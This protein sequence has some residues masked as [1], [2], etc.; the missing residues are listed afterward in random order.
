MCEWGNNPAGRC[1]PRSLLSSFR[2]SKGSARH[3]A[4]GS[5]GRGRRG[6]RR[7]CGAPS[8]ALGGTRWTRSGGEPRLGSFARSL[9]VAVC[10]SAHS[11]FPFSLCPSHRTAS[12]VPKDEGRPRST[13]LSSYPFPSPPFGVPNIPDLPPSPLKLP[14][15]IYSCAHPRPDGPSPLYARCRFH[16]PPLYPFMNLW[17]KVHLHSLRFFTAAGKPSSPSPDGPSVPG[18]A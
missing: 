8:P 14:L 5:Q 3:H 9:A 12:V 13:R 7:R 11:L 15:P 17:W 10:P 18:S 4:F 16:N 6:E 1:P 2:R